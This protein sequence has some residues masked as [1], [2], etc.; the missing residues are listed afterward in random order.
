MRDY[1][2]VVA[3]YYD[4]APKYPVYEQGAI[5]LRTKCKTLDI[6]CD[7]CKENLDT[8]ITTH[9]KYRPRLMPERYII[10]RYIPEFI[11]KKLNQYNRPILYVH[12]D[13]VIMNKPDPVYFE[14]DMS[15]GYVLNPHDNNLWYVFASPL[16]FRP[17]TAAHTFLGHW[18][19]MC[20]NFNTKQ[21]EHELLGY[22]IEDLKLYPEIR[23]F[24]RQL[25]TEYI[26]DD[27]DIFY[28]KALTKA[29]ELIS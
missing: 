23:P 6:P 7:I 25:S 1:P 10:Y 29:G 4:R 20:Q 13:S 24:K 14:P 18:N 16:F 3:F 8:F 19:Y 11:L 21:S 2:L 22:T 15:V 12:C 27:S 26:G 5:R 28:G 9:K 17:D